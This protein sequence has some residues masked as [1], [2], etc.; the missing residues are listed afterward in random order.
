[1]FGDESQASVLKS[2]NGKTPMFPKPRDFNPSASTKL[3]VIHV[4]TFLNLFNFSWNCDTANKFAKMAYGIKSPPCSYMTS[5]ELQQ[6][7]P[8]MHCPHFLNSHRSS[9][10]TRLLDGMRLFN[11]YYIIKITSACYIFDILSHMTVKLDQLIS[12]CFIAEIRT[13]SLS[14]NF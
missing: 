11:T 1:M 13:R 2:G 9:N 8:E 5:A 7:H 10:F 4:P 14:Q 6:I 3:H 12:L